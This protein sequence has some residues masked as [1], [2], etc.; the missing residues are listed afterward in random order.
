M[1]STQPFLVTSL[2]THKCSIC[3]GRL[4]RKKKGKGDEHSFNKYLND[5]KLKKHICNNINKLVTVKI[6]I[7]IRY[8][9]IFLPVRL[10][11]KKKRQ[12]GTGEGIENK[13]HSVDGSINFWFTYVSIKNLN[14]NSVLSNHSYTYT[15]ENIF[16]YIL[17][18][19]QQEETQIGLD[20]N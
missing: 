3:C 2:I 12:Y 15:F 14:G 9:K 8:A 11:K 16:L 17:L 4:K 5:Y 19:K 18:H 20:Q 7:K 6:H 1:S 10:L 13:G